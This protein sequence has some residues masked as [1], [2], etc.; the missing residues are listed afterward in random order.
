MTE[1]R[2]VPSNTVKPSRNVLSRSHW[3]I[4]ENEQKSNLS[5]IFDPK[6]KFSNLRLLT[7]FLRLRLTQPNYTHQFCF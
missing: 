3:K 5:V 6:G 1:F 4:V 2:N 7:E